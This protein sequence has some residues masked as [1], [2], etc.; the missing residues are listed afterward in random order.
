MPAPIRRLT[1]AYNSRKVITSSGVTQRQKLLLS[2]QSKSVGGQYLANRS[3]GVRRLE[4][5]GRTPT[6]RGSLKT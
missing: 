3:M 4:G 1:T 2:K 6:K 5:K